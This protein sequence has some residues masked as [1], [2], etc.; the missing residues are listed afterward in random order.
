MLEGQFE[1]G[2]C[3]A[4]VR[5]S[6][7]PVRNHVKGAAAFVSFNAGLGRHVHVGRE[8]LGNGDLKTFGDQT[9]DVEDD[10][11]GHLTL[12]LFA[13]GASGDAPRQIGE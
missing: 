1:R 2:T 6:G 11:G 4:F 13:G 7:W 10:R 3:E 5:E 8:C 12:N 9:F